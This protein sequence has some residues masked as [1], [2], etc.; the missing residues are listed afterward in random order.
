MTTTAVI[1]RPEAPSGPPKLTPALL[2]EAQQQTLAAPRLRYSMSARALF[3][4][5]DLGYGRAGTIV[6][7]IILEYVARVPYQAWERV[8]YL[9]CSRSRFQ[10]HALCPRR[11]T[12]PWLS[13][14]GR[15]EYECPRHRVL[16]GGGV[17]RDVAGS[18]GTG[19]DPGARL[20]VDPVGARD[21]WARGGNA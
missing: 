11:G 1:G 13:G 6:K 21:P 3:K 17:D 12:T 14:L 10:P 5:M 19:E 16:A 8:G 9:A 18:A 2:R 7:F 15:V 20:P 4:T